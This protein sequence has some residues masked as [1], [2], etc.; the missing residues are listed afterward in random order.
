[1]NVLEALRSLGLG[2]LATWLDAHTFFATLLGLA[3]VALVALAAEAIARGILVRVLSELA[4]KSVAKW[5][6]L[7]IEHRVFHRLAWAVPWVLVHQLAQII[8]HA[9]EGLVTLLQR[10]SLC[11]LVVIGVRALAAVVATV[12]AL[13]AQHPMAKQRPIKGYLQ[14]VVI[15]AWIFGAVLIVS[16][17]MDRSPWL[18]LSGLGAMTAILLLIF[19]DTIL[20]LVAGVQLTTNELIR[21]GDWIEMPQFGAD[22]DVIDIGLHA[23]NVQN[24]DRTISVIPTHRFLEHSFK[25]WRGMTESG[26]RRI[27]RAF[28][29]DLTSIRFLSP[30]EIERFGRFALLKDYIAQKKDELERYNREQV[31]EPGLIANSRRLTNVGTLRAYVI[32]YL[33]QHPHVHQE[34]TFLVRQLAPTPEGLPIEIYVFS[35]DTAWA[36]YEAIQ[37]DIFDHVLSMVPE[38]G[39]RLFQSPSGHDFAALGRPTVPSPQP[40]ATLPSSGPRRNE[41]V[42]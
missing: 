13:Y 6:D 25:N 14:V 21:V 41:L 10:T 3:L 29:V 42:R 40:D 15:V 1:M 9:S 12:N 5:D 18:L 34:M 8:P 33:R 38:F 30:E 23:V 20:S 24:W 2:E 28:N 7:L 39:L 37:A 31:T 36:R 4:Q 22:G 27:K 11:A 17:A 35:N 26:G 19:R 16:I 32:A